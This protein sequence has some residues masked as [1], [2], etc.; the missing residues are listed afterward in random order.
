MHSKITRSLG[1]LHLFVKSSSP[2]ASSSQEVFKSGVSPVFFAFYLVFVFDKLCLTSLN[3][4][5]VSWPPAFIKQHMAQDDKNTSKL[6]HKFILW[7]LACFFGGGRY[8]GHST[9]WHKIEEVRKCAKLFK[10]S[11]LEVQEKTHWIIKIHTYLLSVSCHS[12]LNTLQEAGG[13]GGWWRFVCFN[14]ASV[15]RYIWYIYIWFYTKSYL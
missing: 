7:Q 13:S 8:S 10:K 11:F 4:K 15:K 9:E 1:I 14:E 2:A 3:L 12:A 5:V 6:P